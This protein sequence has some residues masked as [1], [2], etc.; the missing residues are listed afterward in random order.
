MGWFNGRQFIYTASAGI[1]TRSSYETPQSFKNVFGHFAYVLSGITDLMKVKQLDLRIQCDDGEYRG[2]YIFVAMCNAT[3]IGG[4]MSLNKMAVDFSDGV[5]ELL[6][7]KFPKDPIE[8]ASII[9]CLQS[10]KFNDHIQLIK[11]SRARI[12]GCGDVDWSL[13]GEKEEGSE[14]VEIKVIPHAISF[15]Y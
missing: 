3:S 9:S 7:V 14:P 1:F 11:T 10:Q 15:I 6:L 4:I 13:D 12:M 8:L 2:K 5:F